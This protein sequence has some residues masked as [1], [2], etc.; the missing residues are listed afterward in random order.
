MQ[1]MGLAARFNAS[2]QLRVH[3]AT[4]TEPLVMLHVTVEMPE[5]QLEEQSGTDQDQ[6]AGIAHIQSFRLDDL[7]AGGWGLLE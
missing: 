3:N 7:A 4:M 1:P 6:A 2:V 5:A